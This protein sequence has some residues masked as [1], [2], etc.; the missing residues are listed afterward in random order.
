MADVNLPA[1][2]SLDQMQ[3]LDPRFIQQANTQMD[4]GNQFA[5]QNLASGAQDL[6][7][8]WMR[9]VLHL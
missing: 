9:S 6:Q 7:M 8:N 1:L 2:P 3:F 5:Q 4:L